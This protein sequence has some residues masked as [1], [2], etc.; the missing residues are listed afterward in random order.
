MGSNQ[1][2]GGAPAGQ[3]LH[4]FRTAHGKLSHTAPCPVSS[5][6]AS[7]A[8]A[9]LA[10]NRLLVG[11]TAGLRGEPAGSSPTSSSVRRSCSFSA[12]N[13]RGPSSQYRSS[14]WQRKPNALSCSLLR[15]TASRS[16]SELAERGA[17]EVRAAANAAAGGGT[18]NRA[19]RF[20]SGLLQSEIDTV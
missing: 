4:E 20:R 5:P 3:S 2:P 14:W 16:M 1:R 19:R 18:R 7:T 10:P 9:P 17:S 6:P 12:L 11:V 15:R 8:A 13:W